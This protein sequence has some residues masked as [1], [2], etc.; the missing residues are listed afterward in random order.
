VA[1][2]NAEHLQEPVNQL[3]AKVLLGRS[4]VVCVLVCLTRETLENRGGFR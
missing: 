4:P 2:L 3:G 1:E